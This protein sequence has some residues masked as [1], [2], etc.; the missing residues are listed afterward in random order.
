MNGT[1]PIRPA[2]GTDISRIAEM[3]V[4]NYRINFYPFFRDDAFYFGTLNVLD[5]A[6]EYAEGSENLRNTYVYDD[7]VIRGMIRIHGDELE[8]LYVEPQFQNQQIGAK[9]LEFAVRE[10]HVRWLW[11]LEHNARGIRFYQKHGFRLTGEK[12][13]EDGWIPLLKMRLDA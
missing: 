12:L 7:G 2:S 5:T 9:L 3:I 4:T 11:A 6:A 10:H 13:L 1:S 8:K